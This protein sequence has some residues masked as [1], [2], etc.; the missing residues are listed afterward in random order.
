[1]FKLAFSKI[2]LALNMIKP[3]LSMVGLT[4]VVLDRPCPGGRDSLPPGEGLS[5]AAG[6][7]IGL[8]RSP[9]G[10][11]TPPP[12]D[13]NGYKRWGPFPGTPV[14]R[15]PP[16][17]VDLHHRRSTYLSFPGTRGGIIFIFFSTAMKKRT[18]MENWHNTCLKLKLYLTISLF[19]ILAC[20][21]LGT[22]MLPLIKFSDYD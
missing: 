12:G 8:K 20:T 1:M 10:R 18:R 14:V 17:D 3:T 9:G 2:K 6:V 15:K 16:R 13:S 7:N 22:K 4:R 19:K 11:Y 5:D 21:L